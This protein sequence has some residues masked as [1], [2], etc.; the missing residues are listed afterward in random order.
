[1]K[2]LVLPNNM[3]NNCFGVRN[4]LPCKYLEK[5]G[6]EVR[7]EMSVKTYFHQGLGRK[8]L[9]STLFDWCDVLVLN[10]HYEIAPHILGG[11]MKYC[12]EN[13]KKVIYET[14][15]LLEAVDT[16]NPCFHDVKKH[17]SVVVSMMSNADI[18]TTTTGNL[19]KELK[20]WNKNVSVLPNCIDPDDWELRKDG[21]KKVRVGWAGGTTH[22]VDMMI[23]IDV[24]KQLKK[25]LD[26]EFVIFGLAPLQWKEHIEKRKEDYKKGIE[27]GETPTDFYL[28]TLELDALFQGLDFEHHAFVELKDYNKKLSELNLDIGIC[29]L[30]DTRFNICKSALKFYEYAMVG[31]ATLASKIDPYKNE[32]GYTAKNRF[33]DWY[34]KLKALI[35]DKDLR[36]TLTAQQ[37]DWVLKNRNIKNN[38][39]DWEKVY[40][41]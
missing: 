33:N 21:N 12:K 7:F 29:P 17:L 31:T 6:H 4:A 15:D 16:H 1:M 38:V 2:I 26:F 30:E 11:I 23:V 9:D 27:R 36:L 8:V 25:E 19:A 35:I 5:L 20:K 10:R 32:V 28:K 13:G 24:I 39:K 37:R 14:D 41:S 34:K 18:C 40:G 3:H 22:I